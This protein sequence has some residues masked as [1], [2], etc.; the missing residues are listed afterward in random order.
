MLIVSHGKA[1]F[2]LVRAGRCA[3]S[4]CSARGGGALSVLPLQLTWIFPEFQERFPTISGTQVCGLGYLDE[5]AGANLK[6]PWI[7]M[8]PY[9][10]AQ[11][12]GVGAHEEGHDN[13][14][15]D[16]YNCQYGG[17]VSV[18]GT[19]RFVELA[20]IWRILRNRPFKR[21]ASDWILV[22]LLKTAWEML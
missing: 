15:A 6:H 16:C 2:P 5:L 7:V 8:G 4:T 11:L 20:T 14:L 1:S 21:S 13:W 10:D 22:V 12:T 19:A 9:L 3:A 17:S 18:S